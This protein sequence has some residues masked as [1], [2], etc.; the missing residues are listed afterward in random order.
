MPFDWFFAIN[1]FNGPSAGNCKEEAILQGICEIVERH[2][3]SIV[4]HE[5]VRVPAIRPSS[6]AD[7]MVDD[8][9][10]KYARCGIHLFVSDFTLDMGIPTVG[11]LAYDPATFPQRAKSCGP[12]APPPAPRRP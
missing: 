9:L 5:R 10:A 2:V 7:P 6:S 4:S 12:P 8:M 11:V 3:S 1:E